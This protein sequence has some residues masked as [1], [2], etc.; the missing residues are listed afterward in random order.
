VHGGARTQ[1]GGKEVSA[2]L[3]IFDCNALI[4]APMRPLPYVQ[5]SLEDMLAQMAR[6]GIERALVRHVACPEAGPE[7]GNEL[8]MRESSGRDQLLPAWSV[9][10]GVDVRL[11]APQAVVRH[12]LSAGACAA[13]M[14]PEAHGY[15]LEPWCCE[16]VLAALDERAVP[17]LV[18]WSQVPG[19]SLE[20]VLSAFPALPVVL[21]DPRR[22]GRSRMLYPL[23]ERHENLHVA[24][25][26]TCAAYRGVEDLCAEFGAA[27]LLFGSGYPHYAPG[28][29]LAMLTYAELSDTERRAI[30]WGN[31][32]RLISGVIR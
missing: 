16:H 1:E 15:V 10:P 19:G 4:G 12:M 2:M 14:T 27:R 30:A 5:P 13:W 8:L 18:H 31:L 9:A 28:A 22:E 29:G 17:L 32:E 3:R 24:V 23:M 7:T 6:Q 20:R 25:T 21:L 11:G 26:P